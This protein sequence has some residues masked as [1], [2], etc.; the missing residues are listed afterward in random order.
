MR[1][2]LSV[3]ALSMAAALTVSST[4]SA[5]V[6]PNPTTVTIQGVTT[7]SQSTS[8]TC[9]FV[10][11][12]DIFAGGLTGQ[13]TSFTLSGAT[14]CGAPVAPDSFNWPITYAGPGELVIDGVSSA[15]LFGRCS[16]GR[17]YVSW[18]SAS[19]SGQ[20]SFT[21]GGK[22]IPGWFLVPSNSSPCSVDGQGVVTASTGG[23]PVSVL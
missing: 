11:T 7:L 1:K 13:V 10:M 5:Q 18:P 14:G 6:T 12:A 2:F 22:T 19:P 8:L 4:A 20:I 21:T 3:T 15:T 16:G 9:N 17:V 23:L